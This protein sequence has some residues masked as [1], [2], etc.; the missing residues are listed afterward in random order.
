M[1]LKNRWTQCQSCLAKVAT[2][3]LKIAIKDID[4]ATQNISYI[5]TRLQAIF[6]QHLNNVFIY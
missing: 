3:L 1:P 5:T 4:K 6:K 2:I